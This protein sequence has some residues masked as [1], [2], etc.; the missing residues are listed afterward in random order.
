LA[1]AVFSTGKHRNTS[2][3]L[4]PL[5]AGAVPK[6]LLHK[7]EGY[8]V[9]FFVRGQLFAYTDFTAPNFRIVRID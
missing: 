2:I 3:H 5:S 1:Y 7:I 9:P 8:F 4:S 6:L